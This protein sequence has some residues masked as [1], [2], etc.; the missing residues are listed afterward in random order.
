MCMGSKHWHIKQLSG[1]HIGRTD[2]A[3]DHSCSC[4]VGARIRSLSTAQSKLHDAISSGR[5][6]Y[7]CRLGGDQTLMVD[8]GKNCGLYQLCLHDRCDNFHQ[9]FSRKYHRSFRDCINITGKMKPSQVFQ[10]ILFKDSQAVK[11][12]YIF[13]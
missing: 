7:S 13:I 6:D 12:C 11:I 1:Q 3:T 5:I 8:H 2:T 4:S 10:E 9:R